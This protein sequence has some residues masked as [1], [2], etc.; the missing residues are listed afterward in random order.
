MIVP[1]VAAAVD[2][3]LTLNRQKGGLGGSIRRSTALGDV[4]Q[5]WVFIANR[6]VRRG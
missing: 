1:L 5:P 6:R 2:L 3:G 4:P